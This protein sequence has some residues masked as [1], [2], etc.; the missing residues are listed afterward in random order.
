M[1]GCM[2][3]T[4]EDFQWAYLLI[5]LSNLTRSLMHTLLNLIELE[6]CIFTIITYSFLTYEM[7]QEMED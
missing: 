4:L 6:W 5:I 2:R 1:I 7:V 3:F